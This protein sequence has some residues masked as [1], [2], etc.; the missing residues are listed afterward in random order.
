MTLSFFR[1]M[2]IESYLYQRGYNPVLALFFFAVLATKNINY[3]YYE[4]N[5]IYLPIFRFRHEASADAKASTLAATPIS[6][7][8]IPYI[9]LVGAYKTTYLKSVIRL[10]V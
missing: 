4:S 9:L 2:F 1:F 5:F 6:I 8:F 3:V 7:F 10:T